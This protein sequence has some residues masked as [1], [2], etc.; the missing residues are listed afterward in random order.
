MMVGR[1]I[2]MGAPHHDAAIFACRKGWQTAI[3]R[4]TAMALVERAYA[5]RRNNDFDV[6]D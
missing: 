6:K 5:G 4:R 2:A 1:R 3:A